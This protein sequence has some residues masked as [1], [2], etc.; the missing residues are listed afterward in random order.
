MSSLPYLPPSQPSQITNPKPPNRGVFLGCKYA[1]RQFLSQDMLPSEK[2]KGEGKGDRGWIVNTAS[3]QGSGSYYGTRECISQCLSL[4]KARN[5]DKIK[6]RKGPQKC[7]TEQHKLT[8]KL[9]PSNSIL[10]RSQRCNSAADQAYRRRLRQGPHLL[11][12]IV[13]RMYVL[14]LSFFFFPLFLTLSF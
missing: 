6:G 1:I 9:Q 3:V 14:L 4:L 7:Q 12:R 10:Q 2:S 11:Q 5:R 13:S 8:Y